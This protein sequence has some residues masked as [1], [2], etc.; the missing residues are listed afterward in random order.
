[1]KLRFLIILFFISCFGA[2]AQKAELLKGK[3]E[4]KDI[5]NKEQL[6]ATILQQATFSFGNTEIEFISGGK[7]SYNPVSANR[8]TKFNGTWTLNNEQTKISAVLI[9]PETNKEQTTEWVIAGL[10][11]DELKLNMGFNTIVAFRRPV[12]KPVELTGLN[13]TCDI[14]FFTKLANG[15]KSKDIEAIKNAAKNSL[16]ITGYTES[17]KQTNRWGDNYTELK[18]NEKFGF[19]EVPFKISKYENGEIGVYRNMSQEEI[20]FTREVLKK[21]QA[22]NGGWKYKGNDGLW[23]YWENGE[24]VFWFSGREAGSGSD[25]HI[26]TKKQIRMN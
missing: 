17:E 22:S 12:E 21:S 19:M 1:M 23:E 18:S 6:D 25:T 26:Y 2:S 13:K 14:E 15:V 16:S 9:Q 10:T 8:L 20:N 24:V 5:A 11:K 3:W 7:L 4:F